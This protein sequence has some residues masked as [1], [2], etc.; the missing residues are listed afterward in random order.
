L[1][2]F[3]REAGLS[4]EALAERAL[5]SVDTISALERG[6]S[7]APQR[8]TLASLVRALELETEKR[9]ELEALAVRPGRP[10]TYAE[11]RPEKHNLPRT[12]P[13]LYGR[14]HGN[15][16][17]RALI[18][19][20]R[21]V[22]LT[23]AGGVG[24]TS[25]A[26][27]IGYEL[28]DDF[29]DGVWFVD[30]APHNTAQ[31]GK[32]A[33]ATL[34]G[35]KEHAGQDLDDLL[36]HTLHCKQML[37][38]LDNC[39]HLLTEVAPCVE[40]MLQVCPN[41]HI[42]ATSRQSLNV[43]DE[44]TYRVD[45]LDDEAASALFAEHARRVSE[46]FLLTDEN[47]DVVR[48]IVRAVDGIPLAIE[49]AAA[50]LRLLS[51]QQLAERLAEQ[52]RLLTGGSQTKPR[53]QQTMRATIDWSHDLLD[54]NEQKVFRR[55]AVFCGGFSLEAASTVCADENLG[56]W[57]ILDL[58]ASLVDKSLVVSDP[59]GS[60]QRYRLLESIRA[61][62]F[63]KL[64]DDDESMH[65][66]HSEYYA[67]LAVGGQG[68]LAL[69]LD[70]FRAALDWALGEGGNTLVGVRL[71]TSLQELW[72][73]RGLAM[74]AA[75]R[76]SAVLQRGHHLPQ[77]LRAALWL[78]LTRFENEFQM[79]PQDVLEAATQA[80]MLYEEH[81]DDRGLAT[82]LRMQGI[83]RV[84]LGALAEA[85]ADLE[86]ALELFRELADLREVARALGSLG[87]LY[88]ALG[89]P[90]LAQTAMLEVLH[91]AQ[92]VGDERSAAL[93]T[94][95]IGETEFA[96]GDAESAVTRGLDNLLNNEVMKTGSEFR[97][98]QESN[99]AAYLF[100]LGRYDES[101]SMGF[102]AIADSDSNY[103]AVPLQHLT[104]MLALDHPKR[105]ARL[106]GYIEK[107]FAA[108]P[109]TRQST[110]ISTY[111][112]L[113][114]TLRTTLNDDEIA[115]LGREGAA[116]TEE[117]ILNL[118]RRD[119]RHAESR[120]HGEHVIL[121]PGPSNVTTQGQNVTSRS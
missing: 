88:Q 13:R 26:Q 34:F 106:L 108:T 103:M 38:I 90:G 56:E 19:T 82:A 81:Q 78:T 1:R 2:E 74:E 37:V 121:G 65:R 46:A 12:L 67:A 98:A 83:A 25:L 105:A 71:L 89:D 110:E 18:A 79:P 7:Q 61:Y 5:M 104:A 57:S 92:D 69:E 100:A 84:R 91:L 6:A 55:L 47:R 3:R 11:D 120:R 95:N 59:L 20:S 54:A 14:E 113:M 48:N 112:R 97:A 75:R 118:A 66:R 52:L 68:D 53:R 31:H 16:A 43:P 22:T 24:K 72:I 8:E 119:S 80:R 111:D 39:E 27:Q 50:R 42:L 17:V 32:R 62:A 94:M 23:G 15:E 29:A 101:R 114:A 51:P 30:L 28:V 49:L 9:V 102:A 33:L 77:N 99:L 64:Q 87:Y 63:E 45:S 44:H 58:L 4:Q 76:A 117:Q 21:L 10:R 60:E 73:E 36:V 41:M 70:N 35:V 107:V 86:R 85:Q 109:Y 93:A 115:R 96:L 116:M 40:H